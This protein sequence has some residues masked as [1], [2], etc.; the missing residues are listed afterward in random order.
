MLFRISNKAIP[1]PTLRVKVA[2]WQVVHSTTEV[3]GLE[4]WIQGNTF[5][6]DVRVL[7]IG[8]YDMI[9]GMD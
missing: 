3:Q 8:A 6:T 9:L 5:C 1:A 2:N 7:D 4:W